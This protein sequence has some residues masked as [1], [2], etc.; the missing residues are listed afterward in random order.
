[1]LFLGDKKGGCHAMPY[2]KKHWN[3]DIVTLQQEVKGWLVILHFQ[4]GKEV[5]VQ[6]AGALDLENADRQS[7][8]LLLTRSHHTCDERCGEWERT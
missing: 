1:L 2:Q 5:G 8:E 4:D 7:K 3:G 6:L